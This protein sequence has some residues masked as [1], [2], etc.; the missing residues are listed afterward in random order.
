MKLEKESQDNPW[1]MITEPE[2]DNKVW[3]NI[4]LILLL[5]FMGHQLLE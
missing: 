2:I 5:T 1:E 4:K 3:P